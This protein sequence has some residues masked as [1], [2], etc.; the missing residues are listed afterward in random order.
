MIEIERRASSLRCS[1][2]LARVMDSLRLES[3]IWGKRWR[4]IPVQLVVPSIATESSSPIWPWS[5]NQVG[6]IRRPRLSG[7][8][9]YPTL[10]TGG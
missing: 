2:I 9:T 1:P 4:H 7:V 3:E 5:R 6:A 8:P 10:V